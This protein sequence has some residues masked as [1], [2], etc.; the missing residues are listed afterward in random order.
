MLRA[1]D[2]SRALLVA[3]GRSEAAGDSNL[4][5]AG[6][7]SHGGAAAVIAVGPASTEAK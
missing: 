2:C 4:G 5:A 1:M 3:E 7:A 6:D